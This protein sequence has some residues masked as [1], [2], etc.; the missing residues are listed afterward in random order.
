MLPAP[1]APRQ[2]RRPRPRGDRPTGRGDLE[3]PRLAGGFSAAAGG[4]GQAFPGRVR[5][6]AHGV[7][8]S[9][10][11][12]TICRMAGVQG[13]P[14]ERRPS[15]SPKASRAGHR[16]PRAPG[17][18][19]PLS[20][21]SARFNGPEA[22]LEGLRCGESGRLDQVLCFLLPR[23]RNP[24]YRPTYAAYLNL[25]EPRWK[26]LRS[27]ALQGREFTTWDE[28]RAAVKEA[29]AYWNKHRHH[30]V[31]GRRRRHQTRRQPG[32]ARVPGARLQAG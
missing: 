18:R 32:V 30:F 27:L 16:D 24:V 13:R 31:W 22:G 5:R 3:D 25:I 9:N 23:Y 26:V 19:W 29:T 11:K 12:T 21:A 1:R 8:N 28:V 10:K 15:R 6:S 14:G 17:R 2:L 4:R 7:P 20:G